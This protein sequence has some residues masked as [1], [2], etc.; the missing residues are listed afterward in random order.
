MK[1]SVNKYIK[2]RKKYESLSDDTMMIILSNS[3]AN[4]FDGKSYDECW[5]QGFICLKEWC[6]NDEND[7]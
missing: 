5:N 2:W 4:E 7:R 3:R 1:F 6:V